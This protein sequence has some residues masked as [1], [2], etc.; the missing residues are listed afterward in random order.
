MKIANNNVVSIEYTLKNDQGETIDTSEGRAPL[1]YIQGI[2]NII[3]GLEK[4]LEGKGVGDHI[5]VKISPEEGYGVREDAL[6]QKVPKDQFESSENLE[7]GMQF[8]VDSPQ[9][10]MVVAV[11]K[12]EDTHVV[13]DG[14]HPLAGVSLNF[15]VRV[16]D[17]RV[18]T[19]EELRH[20]HAHGPDGHHHH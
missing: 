16:K 8:E 9:G 19:A 3:P 20:G 12:I 14:N 11:T 4:A 7:V 15:D 6:V 18:A 5:Q 10:Q 17:V 1:L 2:G 13:I